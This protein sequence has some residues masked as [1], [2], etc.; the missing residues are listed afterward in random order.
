[1]IRAAIR[2]AVA[3]AAATL[4]LLTLASAAFAHAELLRSS[5][6][7]GQTLER[8]PRAVV[9]LF[10]E[11]IEAA[12]VRLRVQDD[13]GRRVDSGAPYH[14]AGREEQLAV[15]LQPGLG[16]RYFAS[17]RVISA[18]GH[19]VTKRIAFR[20]RPPA[21]V[22]D[23]REQ[24]EGAMPPP[25]QQ[26][27][28]TMPPAAGEGTPAHE[29]SESGAFT[30]AAFATARGVGYLAMAL[31]VGAI[32]FLLVVWLPALARAAGAGGEWV[33]LS[34]RFARRVRSMV[35]GAT[36]LGVVATAL[37]IVLEGATAAGIS[38]WAALDPD[39]LEVVSETRVVQAWSARLVVWLVLGVLVVAIMRPSRMPVLRRAALGADG[40]A[41]GAGP[42][43][44]QTLALFAAVLAL[45]MTASLAGHAGSH[46]PRG[47]LVA[48]DV[49]HVLCM[50]AWLGG[51]V[52]LLLA[53]PYAARALVTTETTPLLATVVGRFSRMAVLAVTLLLVSGIL[54]S[55]VLVASFDA[56]VET[57][58]GRLVLAK[59]GL[60]SALIALGAFNQRRMLPQLRAL[61]LRGE[62]PGRAATVL[63]R[64]V[65]LE[66]GFA[67]IVLG[68]TAVLVATEP[69]AAG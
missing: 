17:Y 31:A 3:A 16:G 62:P 27:G 36:V 11:G 50:C 30:S 14:P 13:G 53:V 18:D 21:P 56:L 54:N 22:D 5:P 43:R 24:D 8:S 40:T 47:L 15:R 2:V 57:A 39:V 61:A 49:V 25:A 65:T 60:F 66:V 59:I 4:A 38:F 68:V 35:L 48:S 44:A 69:A 10:D 26:E 19:P 23:R 52:M 20:V 34:G 42:S 46:S 58:H 12:F 37:A 64:S 9:L 55:V 29:G 28:A 1:M 45:A 63:R 7:D 67:M 41:L 6:R 51:L 32:A 33:A